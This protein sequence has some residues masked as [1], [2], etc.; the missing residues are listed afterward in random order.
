MAECTCHLW[1]V[2]PSKP[3]KKAHLSFR[4]RGIK[5]E[6]DSN[7]Q[8]SDGKCMISHESVYHYIY[9]DMDRKISFSQIFAA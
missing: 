2:R 6:K 7:L 1:N 4:K 8:K 3:N 9:S 5:L